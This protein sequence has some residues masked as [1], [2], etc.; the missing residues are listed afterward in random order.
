[1]TGE[2]ITFSKGLTWR[3]VLAIVFS[4]FV[5]QPAVMYLFLISGQ[6][7]PFQAWIVIIL[8]T[9]IARLLGA[10]LSVGEIFIIT[11]F[12]GIVGALGGLTGWW[13]ALSVQFMLPIR[14]LYIRS[15][16]YAIALGVSQVAPDWWAPPPELMTRFYRESWILLDPAFLLPQLI[17]VLQSFFSIISGITLGYFCYALYVRVEKL[18]FPGATAEARTVITLAERKPRPIRILMLSALLGVLINSATQFIPNFINNIMGGAM[19]LSVPPIVDLT[20]VLAQIIP[21]AGYAFTINP[22]PY[23]TGF[24][25]PVGISVAQFL[26]SFAYYFI[27]TSVITYLGLWPAETQPE[28]IKTWNLWLLQDRAV[29]YFFNSIQI[30]LSIAVAIVPFLIHPRMLGRLLSTLKR[31]REAVE[32]GSKLQ[33]PYILLGIFLLTAGASVAL[34]ILLVPDLLYFIWLLLFY[35]IFWSFFVSF[36]STASAGYTFGSLSIVYQKELLIYYS[37]VSNPAVWFAPIQSFSG[38]GIAQAFK[39]ADICGVKHSEYLKAFILVGILGLL[40]GFLYVNLFWSIQPFPSGA[41][42]YTITGWAVEAANFARTQ[43][44]VWTGYLFRKELI[45]GA[46]FIGAIVYAISDI[47]FH[48]PWFLISFLVGGLWWNPFSGIGVATFAWS[49][50]VFVGSLLGNKVLAPILGEK[51]WNESRYLIVTGVLL[52]DGFMS[53]LSSALFLVKKSMW[54]LPY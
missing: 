3:T 33:N 7:L 9:E 48:A 38:S 15:S 41:Y 49:Q 29:L 1:M 2:K 39:E 21:G 23:V 50:A 53:M 42:P 11:A 10:P 30:G 18:D 32:G 5:I 17:I 16:P 4:A 25:L 24:L 54:L 19:Q 47:A 31:M 26:G 27:G 52:G 35:T 34:N 22:I 40:A 20:T 28:T 43:K 14:N 46:F 8:W 45:L 6:W 37:G 12:G 13:G 36:I 44:W 51:S